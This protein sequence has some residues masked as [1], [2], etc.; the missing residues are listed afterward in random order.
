MPPAGRK[1]ETQRAR[2][3]V[4]S[5]KTVCNHAPNIFNKLYVGSGA[6][7]HPGRDAGLSVGRTGAG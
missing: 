6:R 5:S 1:R 2:D 4:L 3:L 7:D